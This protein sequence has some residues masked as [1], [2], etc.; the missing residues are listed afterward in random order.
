M[1]HIRSI[2]ARFGVVVAVFLLLVSGSNVQADTTSSESDDP[3]YTK[4]LEK[5]EEGLRGPI[6]EW[7]YYWHEGLRIGS[8]E[9]NLT[10]KINLSI[11]VDGGYIGADDELENAFPDLEG[12]NL[13]FRELK[14][15]FFEPYMIGRR[16]NLV[17]T[18]PMYRTSKTNG[19]DL[20]R[21]P[22]LDTSHYAT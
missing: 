8:P 15:S 16:S 4:I 21:Y 9:K 2:F 18:L 14:V 6:A 3:G 20:Q 22:I 10:I 17:L 13:N 7:H 5:M 19:S 1:M 11:M 12:P